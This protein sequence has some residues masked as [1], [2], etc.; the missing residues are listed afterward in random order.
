[1]K[2][3]DESYKE[4]ERDEEGGR[5]QMRVGPRI[6]ISSVQIKNVRFNN[7]FHIRRISLL[8][9]VSCLS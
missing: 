6:I 3:K 5:Q 2:D 4:D 8:L 1:M 9:K 7:C